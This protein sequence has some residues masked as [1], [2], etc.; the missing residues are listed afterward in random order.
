MLFTIDINWLIC[1]CCWETICS[2][3]RIFRPWFVANNARFDSSVE[4]SW[5]PAAPIWPWPRI[6]LPS[7]SL[8]CSVTP[9]AW[10]DLFHTEDHPFHLRRRGYRHSPCNGREPCRRIV[11][12][13]MRCGVFLGG[14]QFF[15]D[16]LMRLFELFRRQ[17]RHRGG[18]QM[19]ILGLVR[20]DGLSQDTECSVYFR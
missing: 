13:E 9:N 14:F 20:H 6:I 7:F 11:A 16:L 19:P 17:R 10:A 12:Q 4:V 15:H 2:R 1:S 18:L 8:P 5:A 3:S